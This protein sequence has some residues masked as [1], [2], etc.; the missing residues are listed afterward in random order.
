[1][2]DHT[3]QRRFDEMRDCGSIN[4]FLCCLKECAATLGFNTAQLTAI[5]LLREPAPLRVVAVQDRVIQCDRSVALGDLADVNLL[6][7]DP[8]V[9]E[10]RAS[11]LPV[12]WGREHYE[13]AGMAA[14][15]EDRMVPTDNC[16]G[17][18]LRTALPTSPDVH[19]LLMMQRRDVVT[20]N[21]RHTLAAGVSLL[22]C[23]CNH[24]ADKHLWD[25]YLRG[26]DN[27]SPLSPSQMECIFW[28][29]HGLTVKETA[30]RLGKSPATVSN[31][32]QAAMRKIDCTRKE[33]AVR[34]AAERGWLRAR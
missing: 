1:M 6:P 4:D 5:R 2:S 3:R 27:D 28:A 22:S 25:R 16:N 30:K 14:F 9:A 12:I 11:V 32:I 24:F 13:A 15:Y 7:G 17:I 31:T 23:Y 21:E 20:P 10:L 34:L 29:A 33:Q 26:A 18:G 19:V 8:V